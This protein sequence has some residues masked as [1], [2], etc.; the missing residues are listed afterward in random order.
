MAVLP[1]HGLSPLLENSA[2][3][4]NRSFNCPKEDNGNVKVSGRLGRDEAPGLDVW[5]PP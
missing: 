4:C 3:I 5:P 1:I 2:V